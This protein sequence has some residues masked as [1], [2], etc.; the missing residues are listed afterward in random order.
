MNNF[1]SIIKI[2]LSILFFLCFLKL[3][4]GYY[5][6]IRFIALFGFLA[7]AYMANE[8]GKNKTVFIYVFLAILFQPLFKISLG[9]QI[10]NIV[11]LV[12]GIALIISLFIR[13][14]I[15]TR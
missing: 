10:W 13:P 1:H 14:S 9:R 12:V 11:D 15:K 8:K 5:Q 2:I 7:L 4:Y 3:P 6:L